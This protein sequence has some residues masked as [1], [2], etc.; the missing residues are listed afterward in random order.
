[1]FDLG[2]FKIFFEKCHFHIEKNW[3]IFFHKNTLSNNFDHCEMGAMI[4]E[5]RKKSADSFVCLFVYLF[6]WGGR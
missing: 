4:R 1:M 2:T 5:K 3:Q 6:I